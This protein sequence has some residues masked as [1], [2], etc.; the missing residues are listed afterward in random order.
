MSVED[1]IRCLTT[2]GLRERSRNCRSTNYAVRGS[3]F[4]PWSMLGVS[5]I[6]Y[7]DCTKSSLVKGIKGFKKVAIK[8]PGD[9]LGFPWRPSSIDPL[10][11]PRSVDLSGILHRCGLISPY[12]N[13]NIT[14]DRFPRE[15]LTTRANARGL[16]LIV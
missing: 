2:V 4:D 15:P 13:P 9:L 12:L 8:K 3:H 16:Q 11:V 10:A 14:V 6:H 1:Y 5:P 7:Y